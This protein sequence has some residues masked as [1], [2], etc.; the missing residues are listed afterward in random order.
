[1]NSWEYKFTEA[2]KQ[3]ENRKKVLQNTV[4]KLFDFGRLNNWLGNKNGKCN[5]FAALLYYSHIRAHYLADKP[6]ETEVNIKGKEVPSY[7]GKDAAI[8]NGG[9]PLFTK[10][11]KDSTE[12]VKEFLK[13][14]IPRLL[15]KEEFFNQL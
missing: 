9:K 12:S 8:L 14:Y 13:S 6:T 4:N 2:E 7:A 11:R 10:G 1:M 5:S 15:D 3:Q